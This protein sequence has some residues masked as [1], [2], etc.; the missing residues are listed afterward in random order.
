[1]NGLVLVCTA[2]ATATKPI[3]ATAAKQIIIGTLFIIFSP[4]EANFSQQSRC[5][6]CPVRAARCRVNPLNPET[7]VPGLELATSHPLMSAVPDSV[8]SPAF[9][10]PTSSN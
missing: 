2:S 7:V 8:N 9:S 4:P 5:L 3:D 6:F 10:G 1:M